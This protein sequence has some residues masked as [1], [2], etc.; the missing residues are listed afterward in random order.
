MLRAVESKLAI[1]SGRPN[2]TLELCT[3][4]PPSLRAEDGEQRVR[5]ASATKTADG[6]PI[7]QLHEAAGPGLARLVEDPRPRSLAEEQATNRGDADQGA[8]REQAHSGSFGRVT[9]WAKAD[10][11]ADDEI[12]MGHADLDATLPVLETLTV[13]G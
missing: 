2:S 11:G 1:R 13:D 7:D 4:T 10:E 3:P 12:A 5:E 8:P 6:V 9:Q